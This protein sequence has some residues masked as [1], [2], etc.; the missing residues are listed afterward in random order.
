VRLWPTPTNSRRCGRASQLAL[1]DSFHQ[2]YL[3][4]H[5][6][7]PLEIANERLRV[8]VGVEGEPDGDVLDDLRHAYGLELELIPADQ[9]EVEEAVRSAFAAEESVVGL[10][11]DLG[12]GAVENGPVADDRIADARDLASH[13]PVVRP[14]NLMVR[15]AHQ[16][17]A[18]DL[19]LE[20]T[21]DGLKVRIRVDGVLTEFPGPPRNLEAADRPEAER[22]PRCTPRWGYAE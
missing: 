12:A 10:V 20:A 17:G 3:T 8:A 16:A 19:H 6:V 22:P 2:E 21:K 9:A 14:V 7:L 18:S 13:P 5:H 11:R 4:Y 1:S 15:E